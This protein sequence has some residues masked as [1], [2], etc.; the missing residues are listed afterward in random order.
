MIKL[1]QPSPSLAMLRIGVSSIFIIHSIARMYL[2]TVG[3]FGEFLNGHG[4][5]AGTILAWF[6]TIA[7]LIGGVALAANLYVMPLSIYFVF[8]MA[9]GIILVHRHFG[10]FVVGASNGGME[11]SVLIIVVLLTILF[12]HKKK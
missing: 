11:Y 3:G 7:E 10:W 6:I 5:P 2:G 8:Q 4:F 1:F 9:M 12:T